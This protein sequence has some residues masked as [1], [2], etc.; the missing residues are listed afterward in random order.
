MGEGRKYKEERRKVKKM[1]KKGFKNDIQARVSKDHRFGRPDP[2]GL[3]NLAYFQ[4]IPKNQRKIRKNIQRHEKFPK[5][6]KKI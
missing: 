2:C 5:H 3:P 1:K 4:K 6:P